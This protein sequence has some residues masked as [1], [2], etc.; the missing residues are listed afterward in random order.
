MYVCVVFHLPEH[1]PDIC[2]WLASWILSGVTICQEMSSWP[3]Q[4]IIFLTHPEL[5]RQQNLTFLQMLV[6]VGDV[7]WYFSQRLYCIKP[8]PATNRCKKTVEWRKSNAAVLMIQY[9]IQWFFLLFLLVFVSLTSLMVLH[10]HI[11]A[12]P[13]L[14]VCSPYKQ[15]D[16]FPPTL[17]AWSVSRYELYHWSFDQI[18]IK[19]E[20]FYL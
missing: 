1:F 13:S 9:I 16:T 11:H 18:L 10:V 20:Y 3:H 7:S 19:S 4:V 2:L 14:D 15:I 12:K 17:F 8:V 5:F 6:F